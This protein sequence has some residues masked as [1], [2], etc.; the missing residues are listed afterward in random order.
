MAVDGG[1]SVVFSMSRAGNEPQSGSPALREG[2]DIRFRFE[3]RDVT[4]HQPLTGGTP[5]AWI[6]RRAGGQ[7]SDAQSCHQRVQRLL[8]ASFMSRAAVDLNSYYVL[9]LND[10]ATVSVV[11]P[12]FG[13]GNSKLLAMVAL[14]SRG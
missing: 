5:A 13:Y 6:D 11:D 9:S 1:I 10:N 2:D 3:L 7:P 4:S 14:K 8:E 12:L